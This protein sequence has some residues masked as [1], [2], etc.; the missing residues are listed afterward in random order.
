M[1]VVEEQSPN[2]VRVA[3]GGCKMSGGLAVS[4]GVAPGM[5]VWRVELV[6]CKNGKF[7][8]RRGQP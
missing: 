7:Q 6:Y 5:S 2:D 1:C 8:G 4:V 3:V